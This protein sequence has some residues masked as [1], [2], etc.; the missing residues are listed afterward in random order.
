MEEEERGR[1]RGI[2]R[3]RRRKM[4]REDRRGGKKSGEERNVVERKTQD[5]RQGMFCTLK[6]IRKSS[7]VLNSY[8]FRYT[9]RCF[10]V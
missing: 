8:M 10:V 1:E 5:G 9:A 3:K 7:H 6:Q 4:R 2:R